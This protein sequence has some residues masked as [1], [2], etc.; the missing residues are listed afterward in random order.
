MECKGV[1][2]NNASSCYTVLIETLW[3]VKSDVK[4]IFTSAAFVLI[5]T[6]WNVKPFEASLFCSG[7][8]VLIETLWNVKSFILQVPL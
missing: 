8:Y 5:E 3:N 4:M 2:G 6:L 7:Y 1:N